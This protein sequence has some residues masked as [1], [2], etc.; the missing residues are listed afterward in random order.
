MT[1]GMT[2]LITCG[3]GSIRLSSRV[4]VQPGRLISSLILAGAAQVG[5]D[6]QFFFDTDHVSADSGVQSN[7]LTVDISALPTQVHGTPAIPSPG[8]LALAIMQAIQAIVGFN[9]DAGEPMNEEASE[10]LV[11]V[12]TSLWAVAQ[13]A[14]GAQIVGNGEL[15]IVAGMNGVNVTV[16]MNP[17]LNTWTDQF[18]VFRT[19]TDLKPFIIQEDSEPNIS[20]IAEGSELEFKEKK[21]W[22][23]VDWGGNVGYGFWQHGVLVQMV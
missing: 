6:G 4:M 1:C 3:P 2:R 15:N 14:V 17:R 16:R 19:D 20:A 22:Y 7:R 9:D 18:V 10:F 5:Y 23:G 8:E 13:Q 11:M 12:P 21:H